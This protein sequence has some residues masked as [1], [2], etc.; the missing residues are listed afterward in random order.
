MGGIYTLGH[1]EGAVIRFN[2]FHDIAGRA[3][4]GWGIYFDEGSRDIVAE[5]NVVYRTTHGGFHQHYGRDNVFRNNII[6]FGKSN[7]VIRT[8]AEE[9]KSFSFERN[10]VYW[11]QGDAVTGQWTNF[12]STFDRNDYWR[13]DG[14]TDWK[15]GFLT[16]D[17]WREKGMDRH[18]VR[19][20]PK[21]VE[22][23]KDDFNLKADSPAIK[24]GFQTWDEADVGPRTAEKR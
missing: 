4:G 11:E 17:Q 24:L 2:R 9:H 7:Q 1:Q 21:F 15:I 23:A 20:D 5:K 14:K 12:N 13:T 16:W 19:E 22:V 18:S 8:R 3:Y 10:I 6:A